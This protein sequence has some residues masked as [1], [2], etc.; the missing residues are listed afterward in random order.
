M[1]LRTVRCDAT[2]GVPALV[3]GTE[4][5]GRGDER[6]RAPFRRG[7]RGGSAGPTVS[8]PGP[9]GDTNTREMAV[10]SRRLGLFQRRHEFAQVA[11]GMIAGG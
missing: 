8:T 5:G 9:E 11:V 2:A 6:C 7:E 1:W 3:A 10:R 4:V